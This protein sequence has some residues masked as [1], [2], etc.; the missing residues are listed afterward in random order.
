MNFSGQTNKQE[1]VSLFGG[2][3]EHSA[4]IAEK[5]WD[6]G[7]T[8][9]HQQLEVL[10]ND[11]AA[12]VNN[13]TPQQK[14]DLIIA[15]PDLAGRAAQQE[16]LTQESTAEQAGAGIDQCT[17]EE[18][19]LFT[20]YNDQYKAKF[21][22]PFIMAVKGSNRHLILAAFKER[23]DNDYRTEFDRAVSE[24]HKIAR[25]R[26]QAITEQAALSSS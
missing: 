11:L 3:Y 21:N 2:I 24:I 22:F 13:S 15:H 23:L 6:D 18:F 7:L 16:T 12:I 19:T 9:E 1:F 10:A 25:F 8:S 14:L 26:L 20:D 17:A 4:W 5:L